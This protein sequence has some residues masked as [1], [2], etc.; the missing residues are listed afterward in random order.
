[1]HA[2]ELADVR[3]Q[4]RMIWALG[5][6]LDKCQALAE[7]ASVVQIPD[8]A[9][10]E[11]HVADFDVTPVNLDEL[12]PG[13]PE[14]PS[15]IPASRV[16]KRGTGR[17]GGRSA[18]LH[19]IAHIEFN[20]INLALDAVWRYPGMPSSYVFDW[21]SVAADEARHF[22]MLCD[23]LAQDGFSY[24]D[25]DAHDGLWVMARRTAEDLLSRMALVPRVLE[26]RGLD[27]TPVIQRK[28]IAIGDTA[29]VAVLDVLLEEEIRHVKIGDFWFRQLCARSDLEPEQAYRDLLERFAAPLPKSPM[30]VDARL[31]AGFSQSEIS[32]FEDE[33][34]RSRTR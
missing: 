10:E 30:N 5:S 6:P 20:A 21:I 1:M 29:G 8:P 26:A 16:A 17:A 25:Y 2:D 22:Q 19:A 4:A 28:L 7:L 9:G 18:M 3:D 12:E 23:E 24:G 34:E 11:R 15:L 33:I 27:A 14:R 13:R 32:W 31:Q